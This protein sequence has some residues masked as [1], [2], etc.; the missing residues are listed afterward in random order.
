MAVA[1]LRLEGGPW[2]CR[3][4]SLRGAAGQ[5]SRTFC[6]Q[7]RR[8]P[9][10]TNHPCVSQAILSPRC[11][12]GVSRVPEDGAQLFLPVT[13]RCVLSTGPGSITGPRSTAQQQR[14]T[15]ALS[16]RTRAGLRP[17]EPRPGTARPSWAR[18][19][20]GRLENPR[21]LR[22]P[23]PAPAARDLGRSWRPTQGHQRPVENCRAPC[24]GD[25]QGHT[26]GP[27]SYTCGSR[28]KASF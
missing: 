4:V 27:F 13:T 28:I 17:R 5:G 6:A 11:R 19:E 8:L 12:P 10:A 9:N 1:T 14:V 15:C 25:T 21:G 16:A 20:T 7:L 26:W 3:V 24:P 2:A 23:P 22:C 18:P